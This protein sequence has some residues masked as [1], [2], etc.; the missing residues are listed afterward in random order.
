MTSLVAVAAFGAATAVSYAVSGL[1]DWPIAGIFVFGGLCGGMTGVA[2]GKIL[3]VHKQALNVVFSG[4][5]IAVGIYVVARGF[6]PLMGS[7]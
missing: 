7:S 6:L 3:A 5:V 1:I 2:L 4:L